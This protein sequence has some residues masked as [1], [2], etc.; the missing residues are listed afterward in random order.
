MKNLLNL[1]SLA[2]VIMLSASTVVEASGLDTPT[3]IVMDEL[4]ASQEDIIGVDIHVAGSYEGG[5]I[6]SRWGHAFMVF[7]NKN[8]KHYYNNVA[9]SLVADVPLDAE[10]SILSLYAKGLYGSFPLKFDTDY[11]YYFWDKYIINESR[12]LERITIPLNE[13]LKNSLFDKLKNAYADTSVL[14]TYKFINNNCIVAVSKL[15][16]SAGIPLNNV[17]FVPINSKKYYKKAGVSVTASEKVTSSTKNTPKILEELKEKNIL[18]YEQINEELLTKFAYKYG[19]GSVV[20]FLSFDRYL[21]FKY[22]KV[23]IE[24]FKSEYESEAMSASFEANPAQYNLC[25][26]EV[27]AQKLIDYE[28]SNLPKEIFS[29]NAFS[30]H[31][32][33]QKQKEENPYTLHNKIVAETARPLAQKMRLNG[34]KKKRGDVIKFTLGQYDLDEQL[35]AINIVKVN[36]RGSGGAQSYKVKIPMTKSGEVLKLLDREC[37]NLKTK[38]FLNGCGVIEEDGQF[39]LYAY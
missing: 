32:K 21:H 15:L 12:P 24:K 17:P 18:T 16:K 38:E 33:S 25:E 37:V 4:F 34:I 5:P 29:A 36:R 7:I 8:E 26:D 28:R 13:E 1:Y 30:R 23:M 9:L 27:C 35:M 31:L 20:K 2:L 11:F 3:E 6:F 39:A 10:E 22:T 14:G 19:I